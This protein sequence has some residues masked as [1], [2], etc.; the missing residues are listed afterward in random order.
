MRLATPVEVSLWTTQTALTRC[1]RS[2][3][4]FSSTRA[5]ST[6]CRQSPGTNSMSSPSRPAIARHRLAKWPVSNIKHPVAR[7]QGVGECRL[8]RAGAGGRVDDHGLAGLEH[9]L[10]AGDD[11]LAQFGEVRPAMVD[12]R[13]CDRLQDPV[14]HIGRP[15][16][17]QEMAA[18]ARAPERC[19]S[20]PAPRLSA[21]RRRRAAASRWR[22][23][24]RG[25]RSPSGSRHWPGR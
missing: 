12:R 21:T 15:R 4:S 25:G 17:L 14:G 13:R 19:S 18:A 8:P 2:A 22:G 20:S 16:D 6:P 23:P 7:R 3:A 24:R 5:G 11:V 9:P 1:S 10:H